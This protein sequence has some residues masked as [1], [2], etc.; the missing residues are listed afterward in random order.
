MSKIYTDVMRMQVHTIKVPHDFAMEVVEYSF[1]PPYIGL[2]FY[3]SQWAD[4]TDLERLHCLEYMVKVKQIIEGNG[5]PVTVDPVYDTPGVQQW[6]A[7]S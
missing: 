3:E 6:Q 1:Y 5:V 7:Y 2:R 4:Y